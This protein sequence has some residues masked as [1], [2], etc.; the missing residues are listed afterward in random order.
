MRLW[1]LPGVECFIETTCCAPL[2]NGCSIVARFPGRIPAGFEEALT[3]SLGNILSVG[4][5]AG[6]PRP[7]ED[8]CNRYIS[9]DC[10]HI[11]SLQDLCEEEEFRGRLIWLDDLNR[12]NWPA[13]RTFLTQYAQASRSMPVLGRTLFFAPLAGT[14]LGEPP[15]LDVALVTCEWDGVPDELDLVLLANEYLR[16]RSVSSIQRMLLATTVARVVSWDFDSAVRL[17]GESERSILNP[18]EVLCSVADEKRW[19]DETPVAWEFGTASQSGIVHPARAAIEDPPREIERRV[20]SAQAS[21]LLPWIE[22]LR[23]ETVSA[24][25]FEVRRQMR[26]S[27]IT[28]DD[29]YDLEIGELAKIFGLRGADRNVRKRVQQLRTVRNALAHLQPLPPETVLRLIEVNG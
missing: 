27:G 28:E 26:H 25:L 29:P 20:W 14:P 10:P 17:L 2:R 7:F 9:G 5:L 24:N 6:S 13:W 18:T 21:V 8:L 16:Q 1:D 11:Q 23:Y 3:A 19:T 15:P 22:T 12:E 4:R